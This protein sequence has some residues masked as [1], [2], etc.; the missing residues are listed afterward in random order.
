[1][2]D[3]I[4]NV[5]VQESSELAQRELV[6]GGCLDVVQTQAQSDACNAAPAVQRS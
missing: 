2:A 1:M 4:S 3:G 6:S 5:G